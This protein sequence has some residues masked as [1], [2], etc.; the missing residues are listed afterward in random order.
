M[1]IS[2]PVSFFSKCCKEQSDNTSE[3]SRTISNKLAS[4]AKED[5]EHDDGGL[6]KQ[7]LDKDATLPVRIHIILTYFR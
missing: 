7:R 4:Q 6:E 1:I 2:T 3:D 5:G